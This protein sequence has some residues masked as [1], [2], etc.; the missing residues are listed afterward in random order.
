MGGEIEVQSKFGEGT[1][2]LVTLP[3]APKDEIPDEEGE[4]FDDEV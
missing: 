4:D 1:E 2:F 3:L